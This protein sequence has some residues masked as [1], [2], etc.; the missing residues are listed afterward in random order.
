M[1]S[2]GA[3]GLLILILL[4]GF[5][6]CAGCQMRDGLIEK[7]EGVMQAW[8]EVQNQYQRRADLVPN[9]VQTVNRAVE[10]E[11]QILS[12]VTNARSKVA[13]MSISADDLNDPDRLRA[14]LDAQSTLK[15]ALGRL[16]AVTEQYPE[17]R[18]TQAF[19]GLQDQLEGSENRIAVAR[20]R[21]NEA[22]ASYNTATRTF[23]RNLIPGFRPK[24]P[25]EAGKTNQQN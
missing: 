14:Y 19:L 2:K 10:T 21:Y 23:P 16:I 1:R 15:G 22:V 7:E 5:A 11:Q 12:A 8:S 24:T 3:I 13:S 4:V 17:L 20:K 25:F 9:L 6:G 18:S